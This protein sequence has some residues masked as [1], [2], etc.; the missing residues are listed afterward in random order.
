MPSP[1]LNLGHMSIANSTKHPPGTG[2]TTMDNFL[3]RELKIIPKHVEDHEFSL[4]LR[5]KLPQMLSLHAC[6]ISGEFN[7]PQFS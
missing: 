7:D 6:P 5:F 4:N 2:P 3:M 1:A